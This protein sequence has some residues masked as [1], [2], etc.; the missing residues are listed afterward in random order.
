ME[1]IRTSQPS[2]S[3][4]ITQ[5]KDK[6]LKSIQEQIMSDFYSLKF[7][8]EDIQKCVDGIQV[9]Q[10][11]NNINVTIS[12]WEPAAT[13]V[14]FKKTTTFQQAVDKFEDKAEE[15]VESSLQKLED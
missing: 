8:D 10:S 13:G 15:I 4:V 14:I 2:E 5:E 6:L 11:D 9:S 1:I 12:G 3:E 7:D